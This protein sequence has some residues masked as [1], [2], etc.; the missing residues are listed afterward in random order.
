MV[1]GWPVLLAVVNSEELAVVGTGCTVVSPLELA[2][3]ALPAGV[4][5]AVVG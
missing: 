1:V 5:K 2:V 3:L 4:V